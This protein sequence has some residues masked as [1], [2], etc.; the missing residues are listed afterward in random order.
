MSPGDL[1]RKIKTT[2][3]TRTKASRSVF[4][5]LWIIAST[6]TVVSYITS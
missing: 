3:P 4:S 6:K 5:T 2:M 1:P